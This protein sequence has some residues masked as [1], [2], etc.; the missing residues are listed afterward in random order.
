MNH[1]RESDAGE[2]QIAQ[3][4][5]RLPGLSSS[6]GW[7]SSCASWPVIPSPCLPADSPREQVSAW[8]TPAQ[9]GTDNWAVT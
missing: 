1:G 6:L 3:R 2:L 4:P 7:L 8:K 9:P 5:P